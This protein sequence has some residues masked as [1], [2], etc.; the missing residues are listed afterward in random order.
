[1]E[2][3]TLT[4]E[5]LDKFKEFQ[6]RTN[7]LTIVLGQI[8]LQ[9]LSLEGTRESVREELGKLT[10]EQNEFATEIQSKYGEGTLD[11]NTG[12]FTPASVQA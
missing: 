12:E 1:M 6:A 5:E 4:T 7:D 11:I 3:V 9:K 10:Q 2:K 8:E